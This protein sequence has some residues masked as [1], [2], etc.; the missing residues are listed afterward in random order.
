VNRNDVRI[1]IE[2]MLGVDPIANIALG[3]FVLPLLLRHGT[4]APALRA[5]R[6]APKY[7]ASKRP[8]PSGFMHS[9]GATGAL[10]RRCSQM[11]HNH[12]RD[13][14]KLLQGRALRLGFH[15]ETVVR[16]RM[17]SYEG[18]WYSRQETRHLQTGTSR[19]KPLA[20]SAKKSLRQRGLPPLK[21]TAHGAVAL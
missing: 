4:L 12:R 13:V 15:A 10:W 18:W 9:A 8:G 19:T 6:R 14:V 16:Q 3:A 2:R 5:S 1:P 20:P 11:I 17:E 21:K 7:I